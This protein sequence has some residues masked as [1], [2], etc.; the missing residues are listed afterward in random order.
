MTVTVLL[1]RNEVGEEGHTELLLVGRE[2][3][4]LLAGACDGVGWG[5]DHGR[6]E[7]GGVDRDDNETNRGAQGD[8]EGGRDSGGHTTLL[9]V[10]CLRILVILVFTGM[11]LLTARGS[12]RTTI[13]FSSAFSLVL[14]RRMRAEF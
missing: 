10:S 12:Q 13:F 7:V 11:L 1:T 3:V 4:E 9:L 2:D 14:K 8:L 6:G 5:I